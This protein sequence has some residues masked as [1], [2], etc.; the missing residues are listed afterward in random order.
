MWILGEGFVV[1][2]VQMSIDAVYLPF[3]SLSLKTLNQKGYEVAVFLNSSYT[4]HLLGSASILGLILEL[5]MSTGLG[6]L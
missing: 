3:C 2:V 6:A 1:V 4:F 5:V